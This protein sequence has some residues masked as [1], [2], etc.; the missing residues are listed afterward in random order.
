MEKLRLPIIKD[1]PSI[2]KFLNMNDYLE[3]VNFNLK[4]TVKKKPSRKWYKLLTVNV[5]FSLKEKQ[6]LRYKITKNK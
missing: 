1:I 5:P 3:F 6:F 2:G 4:Y